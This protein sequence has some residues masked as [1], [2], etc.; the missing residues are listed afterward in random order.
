M[1]LRDLALTV[2]IIG[3][4]PVCFVS[5][6]V[7]S[8]M[9]AW[10]SVMNPHRLTWGFA[11][12]I[13]F[14]LLVGVA[15]LA[16]LLFSRDRRP[17]PRVREVWLL[18]GLWAFFV[19][20]TMTAM[21]P[22]LAWP[23]LAQVSK[24]LLMVFVTVMVCQTRARLRNLLLVAALSIGFYGLKGGIWGLA[25][26]G[27]NRV[28]GP[29]GSFIG[30]NNGLSLA[31]N[32]VL[33]LLFYLAREERRW[34]MRGLLRA[35]FA[36]TIVS[37]LLT[38]SRSGFLGLAVVLASLGLRTR[39]KALVLPIAL[40]GLVGLALFLP[41]KWYD[42]METISNYETDGSVNA[43]FT[44]WYVAWRMALDHP[45]LG[46]GF[47]AFSK[48][49]FERYVPGY[50]TWYNA[51]SIYFHVLGEHGFTGLILFGGL[52]ASVLWSL[53]TI[54]RAARRIPGGTW[55]VDYSHMVQASLLGY[56]ATG[57]FQNLTYFDLYYL[58]IGVVIILRQLVRDMETAG[59]AVP[60]LV[61][62][63]RVKVAYPAF[64][65]STR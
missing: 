61:A 46:G 26:G 10:L 29:E 3:S 16:G 39:A 19:L 35:T 17:L 25:V 2:L 49:A 24:I 54:R 52:I 51:H 40:A 33:P 27:E 63:P 43:R 47:L 8:L 42:R 31:M 14:V 7:G 13:P 15:T 36:M 57:T 18:G 12:E 1:P 22:D 4:L 62:S 6:Y 9:F 50:P 32:M 11:L 41:E 53:W 44:S 5:P 45:L 37:V 20:T 23:K 38:Y 21:Y 28:L 34:W 65:F 59:T 48:E 58:L 56:F 60:E 64:R 30:D 55:A